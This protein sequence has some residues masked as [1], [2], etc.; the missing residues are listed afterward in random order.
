MHSGKVL[1]YKVVESELLRMC[2]WVEGNYSEE[3]VIQA[4]DSVFK[5][6]SPANVYELKTG[7]LEVLNSRVALP[8]DLYLIDSIASTN[9][10]TLEEAEE[11]SCNGTLNLFPMQWNGDK[12]NRKWHCSEKDYRAKSMVK[13]IVNSG[14]IFPNFETGIIAISYL[15]VPVDEDGFPQIPAERSW[16]LA[17]MWQ[18]AFEIAH[19]MFMVDKISPDKLGRVEYEKCKYVTQAGNDAR[20]NNKPQAIARKNNSLSSP[21]D[22]FPESNFFASFGNVKGFRYARR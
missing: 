21:T 3:D 9:C 4:M 10:T 22:Y 16:V 2:P 12:F 5:L 20:M 14:Y 1:S 19:R 11:K 7:L 8:A 13:Y 18:C 6:V 15:G 17:S